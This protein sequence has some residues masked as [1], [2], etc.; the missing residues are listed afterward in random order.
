MWMSYANPFRG[1]TGVLCFIKASN[2]S[3]ETHIE[4]PAGVA[5]IREKIKHVQFW[6]SM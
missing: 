5:L 6:D 4:T 3:V 1:P 2:F